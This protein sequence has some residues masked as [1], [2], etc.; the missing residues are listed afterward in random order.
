MR[1][2]FVVPY[3]PSLIRVR[4]YQL[5][6]ALARRGHQLT[7]LAVW[8]SEAERADLERL[9]ADGIRV[10]AE[11]LRVGRRLWNVVRTMPSR[12]PLQAAFCWQPAAARRLESVL[13]DPDLDIVHVEHLRG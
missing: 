2:L 5:I 6:R 13:R 8:T 10:L 11:R 9:A 7:L 1:I 12:A 4:P 3:A